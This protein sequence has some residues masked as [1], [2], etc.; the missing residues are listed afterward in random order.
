MYAGY[1][2]RSVFAVGALLQQSSTGYSERL[3]GLGLRSSLA[4]RGSQFVL[5]ALAE[6]SDGKYLET[7]YLPSFTL[8]PIAV[9]AT[10]L[11]YLPLSSAGVRQFYVSPLMATASVGSRLA[12]GMSSQLAVESGTRTAISIGPATLIALPGSEVG[13]EYLE[14]MRL[15]GGRI[16]LS[17]RAFY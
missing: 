3:I 2:Y 1:G 11:N 5:A 14:S 13:V 10:V 8:G 12:I 15:D 4:S 7:Y 17:F 16:R 9:S 6:T